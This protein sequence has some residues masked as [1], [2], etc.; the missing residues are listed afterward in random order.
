MR[1]SGVSYIVKQGFKNIAHNKWFSLASVATITACIFLF[2]IFYSIVANFGHIVKSAEEGVAVTVFFEEGTTQETMDN[3]GKLIEA[4]PEVARIEFIS[5]EQAWE[6]FKEQYF[7]D[8]ANLAEGFEADNPLAHSAN[9]EVYLKDVED[10]SQLVEY[11]KGLDGVRKVNQSEAAAT[12]LS[13]FNL[14]IGY[15]SA[16]IIVVLLLV[17]V[18]LISNTIAVG[19]EVRKEE[20]GIMKLIGAKDAVVRAPFLIEGML[21]GLAG[22][23]I[24]LVILYFG[25]REVISYVL[26]RFRPLQDFLKFL[27][28]EQ[29]FLT[30][31][32]VSLALGLG[33]GLLGSYITVRKHLKV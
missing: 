15:V 14:L 18:F 1:I 24:P 17:S 9:Y 2:G 25:Y 13:T 4:R 3:A 33:I 22:S 7:K 21:I 26:S 11:I 30:L 10:Q 19:I 12:T 27:P 6:D 32:P 31:V 28:A 8:S 5:A 16:A 23:V 20:I 29:V